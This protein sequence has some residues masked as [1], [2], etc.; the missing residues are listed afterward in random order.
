MGSP[1]V[2]SG[3]REISRLGEI[4]IMKGLPVIKILTVNPNM[5]IN[6]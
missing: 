5:I 1:E 3:T 4:T 2:G 6:E